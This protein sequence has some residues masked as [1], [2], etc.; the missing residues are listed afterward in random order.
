MKQEDLPT[1]LLV[2]LTIKMIILID[3]SVF[4]DTKTDSDTEKTQLFLSRLTVAI[5][6]ANH[7]FLIES[8]VIPIIE[9]CRNLLAH[10]KKIMVRTARKSIYFNESFE[11][12][13][14]LS[15]TRIK[16][17]LGLEID[18]LNDDLAFIL[19]YL[20]KPCLVLEDATEKY[21]YN[22]IIRSYFSARK[23]NLHVSFKV[24]HGGGDTTHIRCQ[25]EYATNEHVYCICDSD[26]KTPFD[27]IGS[28][29]RKTNSFFKRINRPFNFLILN[30][31]EVENLFPLDIISAK[32][33]KEQNKTIEFLRMVS[34][35]NDRH[36]LF[37]D[38]KKSHTYY[39]IFVL[40][41]EKSNFWRSCYKS[42][43]ESL[44][45]CPHAELF[46]GTISSRDSLLPGVGALLN[47][48]KEDFANGLHD[49]LSMDSI[50]PVSVK[51]EWNSIG[52]KL[53]NWFVALPPIRA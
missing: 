42:Y 33:K 4:S 10:Q 38:F 35:S 28:T 40:R 37:Y 36:Y 53:T 7:L 15:F 50:S 14:S 24:V 29:A 31:H 48:V 22:Q 47:H 2:S 26:K 46:G 27:N 16:K 43:H 5:E 3:Q 44:D 32:A 8:N 49:E 6:D 17:N 1:G 30:C 51:D 12:G 13:H 18:I 52:E 11:N 23:I 21:L 19:R 20:A 41:D 34:A 25:E 39:E 45:T 9:N